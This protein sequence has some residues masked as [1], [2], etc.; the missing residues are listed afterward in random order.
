MPR[1]RKPSPHKQLVNRARPDYDAMLEAQ[2]GVCAICGRVPTPGAR[3]FPIDHD[4]RA[5]YIRGVL[6]TRCNKW[7]W[8]FVDPDILR[9]AIAYIERGP[10]WYDNIKKENE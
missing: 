6:C 5:M 2:G 9:S 1:R 10:S 4:H 3:R 8:S 7:L